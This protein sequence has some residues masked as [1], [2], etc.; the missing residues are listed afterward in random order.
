[1]GI[2]RIGYVLFTKS[3][4]VV[5]MVYETLKCKF[6]GSSH[7]V[8]FGHYKNIQRWWCKNCK[9][10]FADNDALPKMKTPT[11]QVT[12]AM[13]G[14]YDGLSLNDIKRQIEQQYSTTITDAAIYYWITQFSRKA[15]NNF[16]DYQLPKSEKW[17]CD[18]TVLKI[19]GKKCW[20]IDI[21][22]ADNRFLLASRLSINRNIRDIQSALEQASQRAS[23][24][25]PKII[26]IDG[27][28]GYIDAIERAF[29][30]ESKHIQTTPFTDTDKSTNRIERIQGTIKDRTKVM[31]GFKSKETAQAILDAWGIFYN[32]FRKHES[33]N[34]KTPAEYA[35]IK[36]T[37]QNWNELV[38]QDSY[39]KV[40]PSGTIPP[41]IH[42]ALNELP[43][44]PIIR[45]RTHTARPRIS[46]PHWVAPHNARRGVV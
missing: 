24:Q 38:R 37:I 21:L 27:W 12:L 19:G 43:N 11:E 20:L 4:K 29:G 6:C 35:G 17:E 8:R 2:K 5:K 22:D 32:F 23:G 3:K 30:S 40:K 33:L 18:E 9:R 7:V 31:R 41:N 45:L 44:I 14:F 10:K 13:S 36:Y 26:F 39:D 1:M 15:V 34:D 16:K 28:K 42:V 46:N 25:S